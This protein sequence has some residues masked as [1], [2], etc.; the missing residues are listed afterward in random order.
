MPASLA[1]TLSRRRFGLLAMGG[2][3]YLLGGCTGSMRTLSSLPP[4]IAPVGPAPR[5]EDGLERAVPEEQG[6]SSEAVLAF[7]ADVRTAGLELHSLMLMRNGKVVAEGWWWPYRADRIHM[8]HSATKS[9]TAA[10][11]GLAMAEGRFGLD[12][13]VVS[14]YPEF[15]PADASANLKAMTVR[16]L[17]VM[18][19]GHDVETSG[20]A[21]R[22]LDG[23]WVA[24]FMK[25]PV[26][27]TP[28]TFFKYTSA[29]TYMLSAIVS[30]TT[31]QSTADY[32][33]PRL[34]DPLGIDRFTWD[35]SPGGISTGANG[36][37]WQTAS[38]L[39]FA[40]LHA[41]DGLWNGSRV[42]P[43]NWVATATRRHSAGEDEYGYGYQWWMGPGRAYYALGLFTQMAVVFPDHGASLAIFGAIKGSKKLKPLI[44]K[45]FPSA[46]SESRIPASDAAEA[47]RRRTAELRLLPAL[48][49][50]SSPLE[51][52]LSG[53]RFAIAPNDQDVA[54]V[55]FDFSDGRCAYHMVDSHGDHRIVAGF[56]EYLEQ[57]TSM[58]GNRLH[59]EYHPDTM[60]VVA[61]A[62]WIS[63]DQ[64]E[65]TWQFVETAFR[66]TVLCTFR[67]GGVSIDRSV[68]LNSNETRL[69]LLQGRAG[70]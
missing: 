45:H 22:P 64:L 66:D 42:L 63:S 38:M 5:I 29:S 68:N 51:A 15:V 13:R 10:A 62:R 8:T 23:S 7:L 61:G 46:F 28:G 69:P 12:D 35:S 19:T 9:V 48:M 50:S 26:V 21:W 41:Q 14:F 30:R 56:G 16:D 40:A 67:D 20:S 54:W 24:E 31:G 27:H 65:M 43:E 2:G 52:R 55:S 39:K 57:D 3:A 49:G 47:L 11:V 36:L 33:R 58:T 53:Q 1:S 17:L 32:L 18:E 59:H 60:R 37:S 70:G 34:L 6:V 25:I 4:G 44:W